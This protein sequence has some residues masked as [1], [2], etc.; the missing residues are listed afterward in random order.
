MCHCINCLQLFSMNSHWCRRAATQTSWQHCHR[1]T[2]RLPGNISSQ[3]WV[4][5]SWGQTC[6][7]ISG[8]GFCYYGMHGSDITDYYYHHSTPQQWVFHIKMHWQH[9]QRVMQEH[10]CSLSSVISSSETRID[11]NLS[12]LFL[13]YIGYSWNNFIK[14]LLFNFFLFLTSALIIQLAGRVTQVYLCS[15]P[16]WTVVVSS[17]PSTAASLWVPLRKQSSGSLWSLL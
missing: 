17:S 3:H 1:Q 13:E 6:S 11:P 2:E 12:L 8:V 14:L 15:G 9:I 5:V 16:W 10:R 4:C 7:W